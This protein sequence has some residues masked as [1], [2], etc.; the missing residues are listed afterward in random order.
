MPSYYTEQERKALLDACKI[1]EVNNLRFLNENAA[2]CLG[3]GIFRK[4][5]LDATV[6]KNVIFVDFGHSKTSAYCASFTKEKFK[7]LAQSDERNLGARDID[8][9]LAEHYSKLFNDEHQIGYPTKQPKARLRLLEAIEKQRKTLSANLD[10]QISCE[11]LI[12]D[13]D[14]LA[15]LNREQ[16]EQFIEPVM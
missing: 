2:V 8:W 15:T 5:E 9:I 13:C 14:L 3:Y 4:A 16:F 6:A 10:S 11:Y 1:A 12:E 7:I